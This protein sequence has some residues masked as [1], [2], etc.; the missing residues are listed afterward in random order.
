MTAVPDSKKDHTKCPISDTNLS[1]PAFVHSVIQSGR[2]EDIFPIT[3]LEDSVSTEFVI[4]SASDKFL[5]LSN[6]F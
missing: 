3:Q 2:Y 5:D 1:T 6:C 4:D